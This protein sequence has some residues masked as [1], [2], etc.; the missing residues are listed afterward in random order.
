MTLCL[1]GY[2]E[3]NMYSRKYAHKFI[4]MMSKVIQPNIL[5]SKVN[6]SYRTDFAQAEHNTFKVEA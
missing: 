2:L 6:S 5:L 3:L 1:Y 4:D